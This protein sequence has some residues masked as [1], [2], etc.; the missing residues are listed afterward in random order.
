MQ[1]GEKN[2][3][4]MYLGYVKKEREKRNERGNELPPVEKKKVKDD[5]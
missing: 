5:N 4:T 3:G 1:G 2:R